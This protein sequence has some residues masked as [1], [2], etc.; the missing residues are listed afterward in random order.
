MHLITS[1]GALITH[2]Q[3][4]LGRVGLVTP[5]L[6]SPLCFFETLCLSIVFL[7]FLCKHSQFQKLRDVENKGQKGLRPPPRSAL[8]HTSPAVMSPEP[9]AWEKEDIPGGKTDADRNSSPA[10]HALIHCSIPL[11]RSILTH[12]SSESF[13]QSFLVE[14]PVSPTDITGRQR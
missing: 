1:F 6:S 10:T 12:S 9:A 3:S 8:S 2:Q 7:Y 4:C 14:Q 11:A 13:S 5:L